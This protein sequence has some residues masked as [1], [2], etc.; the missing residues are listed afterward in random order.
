MVTGWP[1]SVVAPS[2]RASGAG[3]SDTRNVRST[4]PVADSPARSVTLKSNDDVWPPWSAAVVATTVEPSSTSVTRSSLRSPSW[5]VSCSFWSGSVTRPARSTGVAVP[6][7]TSNAPGATVGAVLAGAMTSTTTAPDTTC[8]GF[9]SSTL[10]VNDAGPEKPSSGVKLTTR[11]SVPVA[12]RLVVPPT[13]ESQQAKASASPSGSV[14]PAAAATSI[15]TGAPPAVST[16]TGVTTGARLG[17]TTTESSA[18][19]DSPSGSVTVYRWRVDVSPA[20]YVSIPPSTRASAGSA[21]LTTRSAGLPSG[22]RSLAS[23]STSIV[24]PALS[25]PRRSSTATGA[26]GS[27]AVMTESVIVA[28]A[29]PPRPSAMA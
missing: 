15:S 14:T 12:T 13:V 5:N 6:A 9:P 18:V 23:S 17:T 7:T 27:V 26:I 3:S 21:E 4:V 28:S 20:V 22:S 29:M 1:W 2:G 24:S 8:P 16:A 25:G 19:A 10:Y 11:P